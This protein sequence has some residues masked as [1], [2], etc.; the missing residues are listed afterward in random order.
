MR[1]WLIALMLFVGAC[2]SEI[3]PAGQSEFERWLSAHA[4]RAPAFARF[5]AMLEREG[6]ADVVPARE[7][8]LTDRLAPQCVV[9]PFTMPPEETWPHI[10]P[11][12]RFVRD[13]VEPMIGQ[14]TVASGYR[15]Q[16]FNDCVRGASRSTHRAFHAL[17][18]VPRNPSVTRE[19]LIAVL[20]PLHARQGARFDIGMGI[21]QARR[22][23]IDATRYRRWGADFRAASSPCGSTDDPDQRA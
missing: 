19:R 23:H 1:R 11:T 9:E 17:D 15:D 20:C 21:Y 18:L 6:V 13:H 16:A 3:T 8:W 7:L 14:V 12:L 4:S 5:E 10:V 22:F 2:T